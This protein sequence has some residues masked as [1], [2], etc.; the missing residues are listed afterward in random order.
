MTDQT[1]A[2]IV[3]AAILIAAALD[4]AWTRIQLWA[5]SECR[6]MYADAAVPFDLADESERGW[7]A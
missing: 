1:C 6:E 4:Y 5:E 2:Y 3:L 7:S